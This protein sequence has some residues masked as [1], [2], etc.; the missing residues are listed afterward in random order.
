MRIIFNVLGISETLNFAPTLQ[1][2]HC[3]L[4][5][6]SLENELKKNK[7]R[8]IGYSA[9]IIINCAYLMKCTYT[10]QSA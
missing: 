6:S 7:R 8:A 4:L 10:V 5:V 1:M 9:E 2:F 3:S